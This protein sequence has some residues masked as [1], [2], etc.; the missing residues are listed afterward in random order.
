MDSSNSVASMEKWGIPNGSHKSPKIAL[1]ERL[2][3]VR[4][5]SHWWP[6][7]LYH[8]YTELQQHL[9]DQLDMVLKAQFAMAIMRH[10]QE[11]RQVKVAR[12]LGRK[13][14]EVIE[15]EDD[16][17]CEFYWQLPNVLPKAC[18][19][20]RYSDVNL[21]FDF[22]RAMDQV[23]E[24]IK[25]VADENDFALMPTMEHKTWLE[26]AQAVASAGKGNAATSGSVAADDASSNILNPVDLT[27]H[28]EHRGIGK[29]AAVAAAA[30]TGAVAT[31]L[32]N[33]NGLA[34]PS[35][36]ASWRSS[37]R[38]EAEETIPV[39]R[40]Q[41][42]RVYSGRGGSA[43]APVGKFASAVERSG[44][45]QVGRQKYFDDSPSVKS[46]P[47]RPSGKPHYR[48]SLFGTSGAAAARV[49][50]VIVSERKGKADASA[51]ADADEPSP[52]EGAATKSA[53]ASTTAQDKNGALATA[54]A[55][56]AGVAVAA[57]VAA[58]VSSKKSTNES[59]VDTARA[60]DAPVATKA[61]PE[62][63]V[64]GDQKPAAESEEKEMA[65][66]PASDKSVTSSS[67]A[68]SKA[69]QGSSKSQKS[70]SKK[71]SGEK[72]KAASSASSVRSTKSK[73]SV[74]TSRSTKDDVSRASAS[75]LSRRSENTEKANN[76]TAAS[77]NGTDGKADADPAG[78]KA[79]SKATVAA[80]V[81]AGAAAAVA[82][83]VAATNNKKSTLDKYK[84]QVK[85]K[86]R[87]LSKIKGN[88]NG[89]S[90]EVRD[91]PSEA[92]TPSPPAKNAGGG[93]SDEK[94]AAS[95][96]KPPVP[97]DTSGKKAAAPVGVPAKANEKQGM[98]PQGKT[99]RT[100]TPVE[101][102]PGLEGDDIMPGLSAKARSARKTWKNV[103]AQM[104]TSKDEGDMDPPGASE[105]REPKPEPN[106]S[107]D[108]QPTE[109]KAPAP[110]KKA[111]VAPL[112][113]PTTKQHVPSKKESEP[114]T[115]SAV[116]VAKSKS[117]DGMPPK[118]IMVGPMQDKN[119]P[120]ENSS[121][122]E[123]SITV[124]AE[125]TRVELPQEDKTPKVKLS[126][127]Q[128]LT[129]CGPVE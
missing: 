57:G 51:K 9:Y 15:V 65:D 8:S 52:A 6:A 78:K 5:Q 92:S 28:P 22:H 77:K 48:D 91:P 34:S 43:F 67:S 101:L 64:T 89:N 115:V 66:V 82:A 39:K 106:E 45:N 120:L 90:E 32:L 69:S 80:A 108:A 31:G 83:G 94:D 33:K 110:T 61:A 19:I 20:S 112:T 26:R 123:R 128:Q 126:F 76:T 84:D 24:V 86:A 63:T 113:A 129:M 1:L 40:P 59:S 119:G 21:F 70:A 55:V 7:L 104:T 79:S 47:P 72:A 37:A 16:C 98:S 96:K 10:L 36:M 118:Q 73:S 97:S 88:G 124:N 46:M 27:N 18:D 75:Q 103:W 23:E 109:E 95:S 49:K 102:L 99:M 58:V 68:T 44:G 53:A 12:L 13:I 93:K 14:L 107:R 117:K 125:P 116:S 81:G 85:A 35:G 2:V 42:A 41:G 38:E 30:G 121:V 29:A 3:W 87:R 4:Y 50:P 60:A 62:S 11:K 111:A 114:E 56:G 100:P 105:S 127:W 71:S 25:E 122:M 17:Y 74:K 54:A